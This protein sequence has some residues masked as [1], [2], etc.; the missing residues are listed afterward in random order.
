MNSILNRFKSKY[1][2]APDGCWLWTAAIN[3]FGYGSFWHEGRM[4]KAHRVS[5]KLMRGEIPA[6]LFLDH[7]CRQPACV[8]P[9][10][11]EPVTHTENV[12][13]GNSTKTI[14]KHGSGYTMCQQGCQL[15]YKR[16]HRAIYRAKYREIINQKQ[17]ETRLQKRE[18]NG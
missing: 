13:R 16:M 1:F 2:V 9:F 5:Y 12:R 18:N 7:L 6:G 11:L 3:E 15:E 17:R 4:Q 10:H 8:N 14:C